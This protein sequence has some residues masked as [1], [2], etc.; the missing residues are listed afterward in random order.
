MIRR[1][2]PLLAVLSLLP[3]AVAIGV[4]SQVPAP[5]APA[6]PRATATAAS[7]D[8]AL[9]CAGPLVVPEALLQGGVDA[10]IAVTPPSTTSAVRGIALDP[11]SS[12]LFGRASASETRRTAD[13]SPLAPEMHVLVDGADA[14]GATAASGAYGDT[15]AAALD[16]PG[17]ATVT[18][19][20]SGERG[21][22][23]DVVQ[24][25]ATLT[26][27]FR[28]LA[29]TRCTAPAT[30]GSFLGAG[31]APGSSAALVLTNPSERPATASVQIATP[32][33]PADMGGRSRVVVAPG[34][35]ETILLESV[36]PG[37]DV[38][39]VD[40]RTLGAPLAMHLQVTERD[41]LTPGGAEIQSPLAPAATDLRVPGVR[42]AAGRAPAAVL[43]NPG[44]DA[45]TAGIDLLGPDGAIADA[46][47]E[48]VEVPPGAVVAVPLATAATGDL[49]LA[50]H[51]DG[52]LRAVVRSSVA[53]TDLPG[54]TVGA[55]VDLA[56]PAAAEPIAGAGILALPP[57]GPDGALS[58]VADAPT[59]VTVIP[60]GADGGA[61]E[62]RELDLAPDQALAVPAADL[63]GTAGAPAALAVVPDAAGVVHGAWIQAPAPAEAGGPLLSTLTVPAGDEG[64]AP[65]T[66]TAG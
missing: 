41:G 42:V 23:T 50:V 55:P 60:I 27:D 48:A 49:A 44:R 10:G 51:G 58:L 38:I 31:T 9:G 62:P 65:P 35:T 66:V 2:R 36:A 20:P 37:Q 3:L 57:R 43:A 52:P 11:D 13:G 45:V 30:E 14:V 34:A 17:V 64:E 6:V 39:G 46:H 54:D 15:V 25:T 56:L 5:T 26:G 19:S 63:T 21:V 61:G 28:S 24:S 47:Q 32:A 1:P 4:A 33:G 16:V 7:P 22:V 29:L 53:G 8:A 40:V 59:A 12:L 18:A